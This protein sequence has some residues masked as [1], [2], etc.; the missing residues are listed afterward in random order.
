MRMQGDQHRAAVQYERRSFEVAQA[1]AIA[2]A[3]QEAAAA[4]LVLQ[5]QK[6]LSAAR[7]GTRPRTPMDAIVAAVAADEVHVPSSTFT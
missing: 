5:R 2:E 4:A 1:A 3:T 6:A 7:N